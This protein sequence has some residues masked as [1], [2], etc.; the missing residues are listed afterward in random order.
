MRAFA[1]SSI[2]QKADRVPVDALDR[3]VLIERAEPR[4]T[5]RP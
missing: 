2:F 4:P 5:R 1:L 3:L